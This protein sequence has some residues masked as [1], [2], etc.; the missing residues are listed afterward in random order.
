[1]NEKEGQKGQRRHRGQRGE[2]IKIFCLAS[3][4]FVTLPLQA[5]PIFIPSYSVE[6]ALALPSSRE[7]AVDLL[8]QA[9][10]GLDVAE[11]GKT[12][13]VLS[14]GGARGMAHIGVLRHLEEIGFPIDAVAG[15]SMGA[16]V[17]GVYASGVS[18]TKLEAMA[19]EVG[20]GR[21]SQLTKATFLTL[22]LSDGMAPT[23][24]FQKW[25]HHATGGKTFAQARIPMI[26][27]A[28]DLASGDLVL[29]RQ[30]PIAP[31]I[32]AAATVP[33][34]FEPVAIRQHFL[35]DGGVAYNVPTEAVRLL[36]AQNVLVVDVSARGHGEIM[37]RPPSALRALYRSIE[38]QGNRLEETTATPADYILKFYP[39]GIEIFEFWRWREAW[40][41]GRRAARS[42]SQEIKLA[43][44][45]KTIRDKGS[46]FFDHRQTALKR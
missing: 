40:E 41:E 13:L 24:Q 20:L 42:G 6:E 7:M 1:M 46:R 3:L 2:G 29:L 9:W 4:A 31:A 8:W 37:A 33:G 39:A 17:G 28:T 18:I 15:V 36:G 45:A 11:R 43:F 10:K 23:K 21:F 35:V 16:L 27:G 22:A 5:D 25:L 30:G 34:L 26:A 38:I 32:M 12:G 14:G 19:Q 44:V